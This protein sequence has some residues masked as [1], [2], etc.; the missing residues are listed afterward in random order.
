MHWTCRARARQDMSLLRWGLPLRAFPGKLKKV[1]RL[2][3]SY[4]NHAALFFPTEWSP[5]PN[6]TSHPKNHCFFPCHSWSEITLLL[7][8]SCGIDP[9]SQAWPSYPKHKRG[10]E[11]RKRVSNTA[12]CSWRPLVNATTCH[13]CATA[14]LF[15]QIQNMLLVFHSCQWQQPLLSLMNDYGHPGQASR[16]KKQFG[17]SCKLKCSSGFRAKCKRCVLA[18]RF[19]MKVVARSRQICDVKTIKLMTR[20]VLLR[21]YDLLS[22]R[23]SPP[24]SQTEFLPLL[25]TCG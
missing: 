13:V 21:H 24:F 11:G 23:R 4:S 8:Q 19:R 17:F 18:L 20:F 16:R 15:P 2:S 10:S 9:L 7:R 12:I 5:V 6:E 1:P 22:Q 25:L 14:P 3:Q